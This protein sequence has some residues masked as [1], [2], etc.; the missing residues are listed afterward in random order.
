MS[1]FKNTA[2]CYLSLIVVGT[3]C[4]KDPQT[5]EN[6]SV[7]T[8]R[9]PV[10]VNISY[11]GKLI[12]YKK[13]DQAVDQSPEKVHKLYNTYQTSLDYD[14]NL[15]AVNGSISYTMDNIVTKA[16]V[17][18]WNNSLPW[19]KKMVNDG[20]NITT[21]DQNGRQISRMDAN[22]TGLSP[23][24]IY[25]SFA[26]IIDKRPLQEQINELRALGADV[27]EENKY[28]LIRTLVGNP[29][30]KK[31]SVSIIDKSNSRLICLSTFSDVIN[32]K[33]ESIKL[34]KYDVFG[35]PKEIYQESYAYL[36]DGDKETSVEALSLRN[37]SITY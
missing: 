14:L 12:S 8:N 34:L 25:A 9:T 20:V 18:D 1:I 3:G 31:N 7:L 15:H 11:S 5:F 36:P 22:N 30:F 32:H 19:P 4:R 6:T 37:T 29:N 27:Q 13:Y 24:E 2:L 21:F 33:I 28:Y 26:S 10:N 17:D 16:Q 23:Q 35:Q